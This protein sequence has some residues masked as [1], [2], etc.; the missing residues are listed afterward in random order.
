MN[1]LF[2]CLKSLLYKVKRFTVKLVRKR[3]SSSWLV[4]NKRLKRGGLI[5]AVIGCDG[6]GKSTIVQEI[7]DWLSWKFEVK[8]I[9]LGSGDGYYSVYKRIKKLLLKTTKKND[10]HRQKLSQM[11]QKNPLVIFL[12]NMSHVK[13]SSRCKKLIKKAHTYAKNGGI[14]I[15]DRYPQMQFFGIADGPKIKDSAS[16]L[17]RIEQKNLLYCVKNRPDVVIKLQAPLDIILERR[18]MENEEDEIKKKIKIVG[19][20]EYDGAYVICKDTSMP[21]DQELLEIKRELW[22]C[23]CSVGME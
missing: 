20:L 18:K 23:I 13:I 8:K 16:F 14:V 15:T 9:Y 6:S 2:Y 7:S 12:E 3:I 17:G 1:D 4:V 11:K 10:A 22:K 19:E 5:I 21:F